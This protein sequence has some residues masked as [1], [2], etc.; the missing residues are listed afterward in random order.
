MNNP[1]VEIER[2]LCG[3]PTPTPPAGLKEALLSG[4]SLPTNHRLADNHS[5]GPQP[6]HNGRPDLSPIDNRSWFRRW[7]PALG[8]AVVSVACAAV[9]AVQRME[10]QDVEK[11]R[12]ILSSASPAQTAVIT[13][14]SVTPTTPAVGPVSQDEEIARLQQLGR[15]LTDDIARLEQIRTE[16]AKLRAQ[17]AAAQ[18]GAITPE[19]IEAMKQA[20]ER[21]RS[22]QCINNLKQIGLSVK[23][24]SLDEDGKYPTNF[25]CMSNE[26]GTAKILVCPADT[27]RMV[28]PDFNSY[29]DANSSYDLFFGSDKEPN[30][31]L[32][33]C[34]I[35][36]HVGLCD[37]SVQGEVASKHPDWLVQRDGKLYLENVGGSAGQ[38][39]VH[40]PPSQPR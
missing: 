7:W 39:A 16:N 17:I 14:V 21:A 15:Q 18:A 34:P 36:G 22:I 26:L 3:A 8:P 35:H 40:A 11:S 5:S 30:Q 28:A 10:I 4:V 12:N 19:E 25:L 9:L 13:D 6:A 23:V 33:R 38:K 37:G 20:Q 32:L 2:V 24:W 29:T 27:N 1:E 31:V